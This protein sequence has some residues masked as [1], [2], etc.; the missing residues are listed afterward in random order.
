MGGTGIRGGSVLSG[1][2]VQTVMAIDRR[3]ELARRIE[4]GLDRG[5]RLARAILYDEQEAQEAV[6]E[7]CLAAWRRGDS[8]RDAD[9]FQIWFE[10]IVVNKC[11]DRMRG[12]KRLRVRAISLEAA[13]RGAGAG[14][15]PDPADSGADRDVDDA[16]DRL[17]PDHRIVILLRYWQ[18]L[19]VDDIAERVGVPAGTVK[20]R[21]HYAL[22]AMRASL[23]AS[24]GRE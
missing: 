6:Q 9:R 12:R 21:L 5:Y 23:E 1:E 10:R 19:T 18:D 16:F 13:W 22:R 17:G 14:T 11:R 15:V 20:S 3:D 8:L 7:A 2:V 4:L 24:H